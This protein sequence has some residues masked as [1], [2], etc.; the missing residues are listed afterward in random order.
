[1]WEMGHMWGNVFMWL[2]IVFVFVMVTKYLFKSHGVVKEP[3]SEDPLEILKKRYAKGELNE[4]EF[5][6]MKENLS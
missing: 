1:M 4:E 6:R 2:F 5:K 3:E